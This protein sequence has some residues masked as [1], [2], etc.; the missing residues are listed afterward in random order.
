MRCF[1][2]FV[3]FIAVSIPC[4][5][6]TTAPVEQRPRTPVTVPDTVA[7]EANIPYDQ[8]ADTV[9]DIMYPKE[10]PK[11]KRPCVVVFHGGGWVH[12]DKES[13]MSALCLPCD[14]E[15]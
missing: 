11:E 1:V 12:S 7:L 15:V 5:A 2:V 13:T 8:Y 9:L 4:L 3:A 14:R 6:Q 10:P